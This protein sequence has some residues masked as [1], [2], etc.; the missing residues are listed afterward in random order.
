MPPRDVIENCFLLTVPSSLITIAT[1][2]ELLQEIEKTTRA[3]AM[4][5]RF[6][7]GELDDYEL[8]EYM[9]QFTPIDLYLDN[10]N[11]NLESH[12]ND[13]PWES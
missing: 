5:T 11:E 9:E 4:V 8:L 1:Y 3:N 6:L 7:D 12:L 13:R 2:D 10:L